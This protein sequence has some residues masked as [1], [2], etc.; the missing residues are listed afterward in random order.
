M[1]ALKRY[2]FEFVFPEEEEMVFQLAFGC[3]VT[4]ENPRE[5]AAIVLKQVFDGGK[6][7]ALKRV[8]EGVDID[9][10]DEK[11]V[12]PFVG[13]ARVKGVWFPP[14]AADAKGGGKG[15]N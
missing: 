9:S 7:P 11:Y 10:L 12:R 6:M 1:A 4:A 14:Y 15:R 13:N 5:A 8:L 2:W 3:G